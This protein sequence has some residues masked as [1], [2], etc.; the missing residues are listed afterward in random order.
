MFKKLAAFLLS[1]SMCA[2]IVACNQPTTDNT[3][4]TGGGDSTPPASDTGSTD[5]GSTDTGS[6]DQGGDETDSEGA[7]YI[8]AIEQQLKNANTITMTFSFSMVDD[9]QY[10][11]GD[12]TTE[13]D[14]MERNVV[15]NITVAKTQT[16]YDAYVASEVSTR[17]VKDGEWSTYESGGYIIDGMVYSYDEDLGVYVFEPMQGVDMSV[18]DQIS[19]VFTQEEVAQMKA[20]LAEAFNE[21]VVVTNSQAKFAYDGKD[22]VNGLIDYIGAI[23]PETKTLGGVINDALALID[24]ELTAEAL[25]AEIEKLD[26]VT[27]GEAVAAIDAYLLE[28]AGVTAQEL[29]DSLIADERIVGLLTSAGLT[30]EDIAGI[31]AMDLAEALAAYETMLVDQLVY[32]TINMIMQSMNGTSAPEQGELEDNQDAT[33]D[34]MNATLE[35][36]ETTDGT[37]TETPSGPPTYAEFLANIP[38]DAPY[39]S[40][41]SYATSNVLATLPLTINQL[42]GEEGAG[43][44]ASIIYTASGVE[45]TALSSQTT[46]T[47]GNLYNISKIESGASFGYT[48]PNTSYEVELNYSIDSISSQTTTIALPEDAAS[49]YGYWRLDGNF[50]NLSLDYPSAEDFAAGIGEGRLEYPECDA[51]VY[52]TYEF[53]TEYTDTVEITITNISML[54]GDVQFDGDEL[55]TAL[56]GDLT[57]SLS[58]SVSDN[59]GMMSTDFEL[60]EVNV[61][62]VIVYVVDENGNPLQGYDVWYSCSEDGIV[63]ESTDEAGAIYIIANTDISDWYARAAQDGSWISEKVYLTEFDYDEEYNV[64]TYTIVITL[65]E[66][67]E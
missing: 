29:K 10:V 36:D 47:F 25:L 38:E 40:A 55:K 9:S 43:K 30:Q 22:A 66:S 61:A 5:T 58:I 35:E 41:I 7:L 11:Y 17:Y 53:P 23:D 48:A 62:E 39:D 34:A 57:Y 63:S 14:Y 44:V 67:K 65:G 3:G 1:M 37:A 27:V 26:T 2:S 64:Y 42:A 56:N 28:T 4:S 8:A 59:F 50:E 13:D 20:L 18:M 49:V 52:F 15:A 19:G 6:G 46:V 16:G 51:T 12:G 45:I 54:N 32:D 33:I 60:P 24:P 31:A 21:T